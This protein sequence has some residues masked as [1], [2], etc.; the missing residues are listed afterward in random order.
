MRGSGSPKGC[1]LQ[2]EI[3]GRPQRRELQSACPAGQPPTQK[4]AVAAEAS[5]VYLS[6]AEAGSLG[7]V[8]GE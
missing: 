7:Q 4:A 1:V 3:Y 2:A 5:G 6:L 8:L